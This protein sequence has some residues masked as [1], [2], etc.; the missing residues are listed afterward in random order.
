MTVTACER[1]MAL[2]DVMVPWSFSYIMTRGAAAAEKGRTFFPRD[3]GRRYGP[4]AFAWR[5]GGILCRLQQRR[6]RSLILV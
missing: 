4:G 1:C 3:P 6:T 2:R 5:G